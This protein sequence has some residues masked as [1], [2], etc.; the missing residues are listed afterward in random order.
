[1]NAKTNDRLRKAIPFISKPNLFVM[2]RGIASL[3]VEEQILVM[4][5][6]KTF[7]NFNSEND[8]YQEHDFGSIEH[9]EEKIFWKIDDY[10][11]NEGYQLVLTIML[12][13]EY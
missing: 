13:S 6:V 7:N 2:T 8:P 11:G 10:A 4:R 3:P 1:M 12:A 5:K 9:N